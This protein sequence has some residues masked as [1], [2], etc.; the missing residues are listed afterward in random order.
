MRASLGQP[1]LDAQTG[2]VMV[3]VSQLLYDNES[4]ISL[5]VSL[6]AIQENTEN[7]NLNGQGYG[8]VCDK[9][10]LV[11]THLDKTQIGQNYSEGERAAFMKG[12]ADNDGG[13]FQTVLEGQKVTVF[14]YSIMDEWYVVMVITN[15]NLYH[16]VRNLIYYDLGVG[17]VLYIIIVF[18]CTRSKKSTD[19]T[20]SQLDET[21]NELM[22]LNNMVMQAFAKTIDAMTSNRSYRYA[23]PQKIVRDELESAVKEDDEARIRTLQKGVMNDYS[24]V[25]EWCISNDKNI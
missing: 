16:S 3:S 15:A 5:D 12:V 24:A 7:I 19:A 9:S 22:E 11:I 1:Y 4:V 21:N 10:G 14:S 2:T 13:S 6:E 8:F 23:L 20:M 25:L 18:F 17:L